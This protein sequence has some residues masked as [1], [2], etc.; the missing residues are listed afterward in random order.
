M[1]TLFVKNTFSSL[2][3][4]LS[5]SPYLSIYLSLSVYKTI[6]E[7]PDASL[8][9]APCKLLPLLTPHAFL[10]EYGRVQSYCGGFRFLFLASILNQITSCCILRRHRRRRQPGIFIFRLFWRL[11]FKQNVRERDLPKYKVLA[12][13]RK[14]RGVIF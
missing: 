9:I 2:S 12:V 6:F 14:E 8:E 7:I 13:P 4:S 10:L 11:S 3:L 1:T 5:L